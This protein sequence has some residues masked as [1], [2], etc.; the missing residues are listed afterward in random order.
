MRAVVVVIAGLLFATLGCTGY[1]DVVLLNLQ[2]NTHEAAAQAPAR[3]LKVEVRP[4]QSPRSIHLFSRTHLW[5]GKTY[6]AVPGGDPPALMAKIGA[7]FFDQ[8]GWAAWVGGAEDNGGAT[9]PDVVVSGTVQSFVAQ[10]I[11]H[12]GFTR[13]SARL[14]VD[15]QAVNR[16]DSSTVRMS[17]S[18]EIVRRVFWYGP[19]DLE[20]VI[21]ELITNTFSKFAKGTRMEGRSLRIKEG[22]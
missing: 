18:D 14:T 2:A 17:Y 7:D 6:Y 10:S 12:Y 20:R 22:A 4:F 8:Q 21:N 11:S 16:E 1:G 9:D 3:P 5:G 13:I 15:L 19:E